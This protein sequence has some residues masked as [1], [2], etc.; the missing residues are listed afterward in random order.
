MSGPS[1]PDL[2]KQNLQKHFPLGTVDQSLQR[3]R[4]IKATSKELN[5]GGTRDSRDLKALFNDQ[6]FTIMPATLGNS[7]Y[8]K[9]NLTSYRSASS[10]NHTNGRSTPNMSMFN[11]RFSSNVLQ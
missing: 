11:K 7:Q 3:S 4:A 1:Y 5:L 9:D 8:I 6:S 2:Y 10:Q